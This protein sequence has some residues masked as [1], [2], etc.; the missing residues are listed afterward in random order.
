MFKCRHKFPTWVWS[1]CRRW[2]MVDCQRSLS[3][4]IACNASRKQTNKGNLENIWFMTPN[5]GGW[6]RPT[7]LIGPYWSYS[8]IYLL[9][10]FYQYSVQCWSHPSIRDPQNTSYS[11]A[12]CWMV[13]SYTTHFGS[14]FTGNSLFARLGYRNIEVGSRILLK[15]VRLW[16]PIT[17]LI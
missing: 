7:Q 1:A 8:P 12:I 3:C 4:L 6:E 16:E 2:K 14:C 13:S 9:Y 5:L 15:T 10:I 11:W 17:F